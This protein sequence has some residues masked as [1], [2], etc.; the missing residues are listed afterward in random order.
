MRISNSAEMRYIVNLFR[1]LLG[2]FDDDL[3]SFA[4]ANSSVKTDDWSFLCSKENSSVGEKLQCRNA[5]QFLPAAENMMPHTRHESLLDLS[6]N[7]NFLD[8]SEGQT[9]DLFD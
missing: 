7:E 5:S 4:S 2:D 6:E 9:L 3:L 8:H 1:I